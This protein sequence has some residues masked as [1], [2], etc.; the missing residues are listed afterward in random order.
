MQTDGTH[1]SILSYSIWFL[2]TDS[3]LENIGEEKN[4]QKEKCISKYIWQFIQI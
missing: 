2:A 1:Y 4:V 3:Y